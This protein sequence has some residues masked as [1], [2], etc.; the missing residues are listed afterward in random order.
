MSY[1]VNPDCRQD[2]EDEVRPVELLVQHGGR[3]EVAEHDDRN[4]AG[5][6][7]HQDLEPQQVVCLMGQGCQI[8]VDSS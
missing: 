8:G 1:E 3:E 5:D 7:V 4:H 2:E 6:Q